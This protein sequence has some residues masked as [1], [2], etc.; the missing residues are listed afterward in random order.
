MNSI[1]HLRWYLGHGEGAVR[2]RN[3]NTFYVI[4]SAYCILCMCIV[5]IIHNNTYEHIEYHISF[6]NHLL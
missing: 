5:C 2:D 4:M 6:C 3:D 1:W